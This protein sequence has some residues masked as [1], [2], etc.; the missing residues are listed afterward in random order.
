[1]AKAKLLFDSWPWL[2]G[3]VFYPSNKGAWHIL[4]KYLVLM[5]SLSAGYKKKLPCSLWLWGSKLSVGIIVGFI[6]GNQ[7]FKRYC[8]TKINRGQKW[9]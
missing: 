1:V 3:D 7:L 9:Y 2:A 8:P 6:F 5:K 4:A